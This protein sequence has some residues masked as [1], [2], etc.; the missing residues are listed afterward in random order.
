[1]VAP[2][3]TLASNTTTDVLGSG[4]EF[5]AISG[6][7]TITSFGTGPNRKRFCRA[8]GAFTIKHNA[9]SLIC[10]GGHDIK[11]QAGDTFIVVSDA[12][13]TARIHSYQRAS[14]PPPF[15]PVG[16]IVDYA[17]DTAPPF[18]LLCYGQEVS[19]TPHA[20]LFDAVGVT[21]GAGN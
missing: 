8:T 3:V 7:N 9:T 5:V 2:E 6:T 21:Y 20:A 12:T 18:W 14:A 10:P 11:A 15:L 19:L 16:T 13:S 1:G 4:S 17:G